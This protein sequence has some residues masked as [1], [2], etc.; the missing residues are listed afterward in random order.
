M[1]VF[2]RMFVRMLSERLK[3]ARK[4]LG[5]SQQAMADRLGI[6]LRSQQNY[7]SGDRV[8]DATYLAAI[9]AVGVDVLYVLTG[10]S[11]GGVSITEG[12]RTL[13]NLYNAAPAQV[14]EGVRTTLGAFQPSAGAGQKVK[15]KAA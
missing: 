8:P 2:L 12:E 10:Q 3:Q 11:G 14:Q 13:L 9:A 5:L 4:E 1:Q 6:S 7:E 15:R